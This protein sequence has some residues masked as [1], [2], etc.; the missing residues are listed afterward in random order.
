MTEHYCRVQLNYTVLLLNV[1]DTAPVVNLDVTSRTISESTIQPLRSNIFS[2]ATVFDPDLL[3]VRRLVIAVADASGDPHT[4]P[5]CTPTG[6]SDS[7][8]DSSTN[9]YFTDCVTNCGYFPYLDTA[10]FP[11]LQVSLNGPLGIL[12]I[13]SPSGKYATLI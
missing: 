4:L 2:G 1:D 8:R 6:V 13:T 7:C 9:P 3:P 10:S 11:L 12:T 5:R